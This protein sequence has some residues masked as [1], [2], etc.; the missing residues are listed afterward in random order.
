MIITDQDKGIKS[1]INKILQ[2]AGH[3]FCSWHRR[4]NIVL[5]CG[6]AGGRV[7]YTALWMFNKLGECR[8][9]DQWGRQRDQYFPKM[10]KKHLQ[11]L[12]SVNDASQHA[13]K[14]C[15][16]TDNIYLFHRTTLQGSEVMN[17]VNQEIHS[18]IAVCPVNAT[19]LS[20]KAECKRF[21]YQRAAAWLSSNKLT[22]R[23]EQEYKEVF[24]GVNYRDFSIN[25]IDCGNIGLEISVMRNIVGGRHANTVRIPK[26]QTKGSY[27]RR[28]T[29][30]LPQCNAIPC[31]HM[32]AVVLS[33]QISV[34]S[35]TNI[36]PFWWMRAQ[37][38]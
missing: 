12:N 30:G 28:C 23:G 8:L 37:W 10:H 24:E 2:S 4:K 17:A 38:Q 31:E 5:Q 33:S 21:R 9:V 35:Q 36:I 27:F 7:P 32:A 1:A 20:I 25:V 11:Y 16:V 34:L 19:M 18:R 3:F 26:E 29:C 14:R 22:P 13:V 15:K 6:G